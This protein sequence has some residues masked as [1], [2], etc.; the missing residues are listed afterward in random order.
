MF[1]SLS[2]RLQDVFKSL[3]GDVRLTPESVESALLEAMTN[4]MTPKE[5]RNHQLISGSRRR[6]IAR[7][8]GTTVEDLNRL[9]KQFVEMRKMLK[10]VGGGGR[11]GKSKKA[12]HGHP[13]FSATPFVL[14]ARR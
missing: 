7:G 12:R 3:R 14:G 9:L 2:A 4:S 8:S 11:R 6:R 5:R 10:R 1:E 13:T